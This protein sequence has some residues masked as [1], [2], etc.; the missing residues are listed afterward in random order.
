MG[1]CI[2]L[3]IDLVAPPL[4]HHSDGVGCSWL[5]LDFSGIEKVVVVLAFSASQVLIQS[6][7][8]LLVHDEDVFFAS[9]LFFDTNPVAN[10]TGSNV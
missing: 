6:C 2:D 3:E 1:T 9:L 8:D 5:V 4:N 10:A 7:F